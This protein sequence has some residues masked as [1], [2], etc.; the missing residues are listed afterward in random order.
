MEAEMATEQQIPVIAA[1]VVEY[2]KEFSSLPTEDSQWF[3]NHTKEA[4]ALCVS[5]ITNRVKETVQAAVTL[6]SAV[7]AT[8]TVSATT[9]KFFAKDKFKVDTSKEAKVK[10]SSLGDNFAKWFLGKIEDPFVGSNLAKR[11]LER[12][13]LD[14]PIIAELGGEEKAEITLTELYI[15]ME[16]GELDKNEWH[17]GYI[18]DVNSTL[19][20][21]DVHWDDG[22]WYVNAN[23][24]KNLREWRAGRRVFSHNSLASQTA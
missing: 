18:R 5:A 14:G 6:L 17:L 10:I 12:N 11:R 24:V 4:I 19:R 20:A 23:S 9:E 15:M 22:G 7:I 3:I 16:D 1:R 8:F 13:A 2:Q 21:V